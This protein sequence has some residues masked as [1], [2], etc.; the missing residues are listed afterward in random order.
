M[1]ESGA[2]SFGW[3]CA[4]VESGPG[5]LVHYNCATD[6]D[7]NWANFGAVAGAARRLPTQ[8]FSSGLTT[9]SAG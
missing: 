2:G 8:P 3:T 1:A 9:R 6:A 4:L 5:P 7:V